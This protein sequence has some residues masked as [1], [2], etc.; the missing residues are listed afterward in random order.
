MVNRVATFAYTNTMITENMRLQTKYADINTQ[1]S[2][3][4]KSQSYKG[5]ARDSQYLLAIESSSD[6]LDAYNANANTALA[7]INTMYSTMGSI[8]D[9][10]N[11]ILSDITAAL[12]GNGVTP[13]VM[14]SQ[15]QIGMNELESLLNLR[16]A[17][18]YAFSGTD[19]DTAPV[20]LADPGWVAQSAPSVANTAYYQG[21]SSVMSVQ[22]SETMT[23]DYGVKADSSGFEKLFRAYNLV[24]NN[25]GSTPDLQE[26]S[27]L[28]KTAIDEIANTRS[29]LSTH[30]NTVQG[31]I[32]KNEQDNS[33]LDSLISTIKETDIPTASV[34]LTEIQGQ[35]EAAYSASARLLNL[36][37]VKYLS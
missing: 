29:V 21:N 22:V 17:G 16:I 25:P 10:A 27:T 36:S 11:S 14:Q 19:I 9:L 37:L 26:A 3:G 24:Y 6:K 7:T 8:D 31:Q 4:L 18:R 23:V 1:I 12:G 30:A 33:F 20:N 32:D 5:I 13:A 34:Q 28:V 35:L 2:S 15:A